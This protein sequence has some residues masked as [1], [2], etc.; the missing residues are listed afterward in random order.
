MDEDHQQQFHANDVTLGKTRVKY[1]V[2]IKPE[3]IFF[4]TCLYSAFDTGGE[5]WKTKQLSLLHLPGPADVAKMKT[6]YKNGV[7]MITIPKLP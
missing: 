2:A 4:S 1:G 7:L 6:D 5:I 3:Q